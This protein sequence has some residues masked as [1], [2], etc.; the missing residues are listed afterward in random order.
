MQDLLI[1]TNVLMLLLIGRWD[2]KRIPSFRRTATFTLADFDLLERTLPRYARLVTTAAVL[3]EVSNPMGN[4]FHRT[5]AATVV[6]VC[7]AFIEKGLPKNDVFADHAFSR[8]GFADASI[9]AVTDANT[10]V[11]TDDVHLYLAALGQ[12]FQAINFRHLR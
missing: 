10:V 5:I 2:R 9:L 1:D 12:D 7:G 11:L 8:L 3:T 4:S 6:Q